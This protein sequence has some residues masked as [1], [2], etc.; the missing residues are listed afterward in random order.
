MEVDSGTLLFA[1]V[2][3]PTQKHYSSIKFLFVL[4][5]SFTNNFTVS[6]FFFMDTYVSPSCST[7]ASKIPGIWIGE[8]IRI[9]GYGDGRGRSC[10]MNQHRDKRV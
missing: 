1:V 4:V 6:C 2:E 9:D 8:F 10:A 3:R 7:S 5:S